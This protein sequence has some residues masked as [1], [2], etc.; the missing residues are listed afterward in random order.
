MP[1][2]SWMSLTTGASAMV[3]RLAMLRMWCACGS[4]WSALLPG[5]STASHWCSDLLGALISTHVAP[6]SRYA[7]AP[8]RV[9]ATTC[10]IHDWL[11]AERRPVRQLL[12]RAEVRDLAVAD[13]EGAATGSSR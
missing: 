8:E 1:K 6:R 13:H 7:W 11:H 5:S 10:G 4:K 2:R 3:V 12:A 9:T